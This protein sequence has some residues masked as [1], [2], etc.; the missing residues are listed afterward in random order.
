MAV[1]T[2]IG[3]DDLSNGVVVTSF[4]MVVTLNPVVVTNS[5]MDDTGFAAVNSTIARADSNSASVVTNIVAVDE[6]SALYDY[7][8]GE[9]VTSIVADDSCHA[10][11]RLHITSC[12]MMLGK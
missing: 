2:D 11:G 4:A 7:G 12:C 3:F 9:V 8:N 10:S 6:T 5:A 1:A